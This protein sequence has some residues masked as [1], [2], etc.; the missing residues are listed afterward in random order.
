MQSGYSMLPRFIVHY[1]LEYY[2]YT[3]QIL[4]CLLL[5]FDIKSN[6]ALFSRST[7]SQELAIM[8]CKRVNVS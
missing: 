8:D 1:D 6:L 3:I 2:P 7:C 5:F 4:P